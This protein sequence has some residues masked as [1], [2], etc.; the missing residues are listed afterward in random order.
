MLLDFAA[1]CRADE[2]AITE[3]LKRRGLAVRVHVFGKPLETPYLQMAGP[4][5]RYKK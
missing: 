4:A 3:E 2:E 5:E 1:T